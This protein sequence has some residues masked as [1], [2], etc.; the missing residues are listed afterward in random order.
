VAAYV[1]SCPC[2]A[3][4]DGA[5][6]EVTNLEAQE[7]DASGAAVDTFRGPWQGY[8]YFM[9]MTRWASCQFDVCEGLHVRTHMCAA[10]VRIWCDSTP[11]M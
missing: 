11:N 1:V 4:G 10:L 2:R 9:L 5:K 8:V 3:G 6:D 7:Q